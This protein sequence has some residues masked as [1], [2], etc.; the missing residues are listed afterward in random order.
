MLWASCARQSTFLL[1]AVVAAAQTVSSSLE[2]TVADSSR[3]VVPAAAVVLTNLDT[4]TALKTATDNAGSYAFPSI[5]AGTYRL[6]VTRDGFSTYEL[7]QF[8]VAAAQHT[9]Q[10]IVLSVG[11]VTQGVTVNGG[12]LVNV[13]EKSSNDLGTLIEHQSVSELPL[14]GR[15]FLQLGLISGATQTSGPTQNTSMALQYQGAGRSLLTINVGG[16]ENDFTT[17]LIDGLQ[18]V[19]SRAGNMSLGLS[20]GAIDQFQVHYGFFLPDLGP[21]P[22]VVDL[23]TKSGTNHIHGEAYEYLRN[24]DM[25]ARNYFSAT[26]PGPY[27]RNQFG[28][29]MGGPIRKDKIFLFGSYEGLRQV[30]S[31]FAGAFTPTAAMFNGDFSAL[32]AAIYNP[33]SFDPATGKRLPFAGNTIPAN[34][35]NPVSKKLLSYYIPGSSYFQTPF[36]VTGNPRSTLSSDQFLVRGD[37]NL[38]PR[39]R[40]FTEFSYYNS[41]A[42]AQGLFPFAG[43]SFPLDAEM[44]AL[45]WTSTLSATQVNELRLGFVRNSVYSLGAR[46]AGVQNQLG[47]T[48]TADPDGVPSITLSGIGGFGQQAGRLGNIDDS[49]QV[50]DSF[51]WLRG[52]HLIKIGADV[53]YIRSVQDSANAFARG[54]II[55]T[56]AFTPQLAANA[57]GSLAPVAGSGNTVA[58]FLLGMPTSGS[59]ASMPHTHYR[60][61]VFEPYIQD[62]WKIRPGLTLNAGLA[63]FLTTPPNPVGGDANY[64]HGFDFTTGHVLYA[65]LGQIS[66]QVYAMTTSNFA[67]RVGLAWEPSFVKNTVVRAG[68][69][70]YYGQADFFDSQYSIVAPGITIAQTITNRQPSPTYVLGANVLPPISTQTITPAFALTAAGSLNY[71]PP[72]NRTPYVEQWNFDIQHSFGPM[73]LLDVAYMGSEGHHLRASWD[74]NDCFEPQTRQC[75]KPNPYPAFP[76][77]SEVSNVANSNTN[78]LLVKFRR[79]FSNGLS[80]LANYTF[81]KT[82]TASSMGG[83]GLTATDGNCRNCD[84]GPALF[85]VPHA[86]VVSTVWDLPFAR[87]NRW[88]GGWGIDFLAS[89]KKGTPFTVF[90]PNTTVWTQRAVHANRS[91]NGRDELSNKDVRSNGLYWIQTSCFAPPPSGFLGNSGQAIL[92]GPGINT[93]DIGVHKDFAIREGTKLQVRGEFFNAFNHAQFANPDSGSTDVNFGKVIATQ[94]D[95]RQLQVSMRLVF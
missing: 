58:D 13:L 67:P 44:A 15:N 36:N 29:D 9:S 68:W 27:H 8:K 34:L 40:L 54:Q 11:Q 72:I 37:I 48:G 26:P 61:T 3:A 5:P 89:F 80:V 35:L 84:Y 60:W 20:L 45:G 81:S 93:W 64:P 7:S 66:P 38:S 17:Y 33:L 70:I 76:F 14:N 2:G 78:T 65:A 51:S 46:N 71:V 92:T 10:D 16:N 21:N 22:G 24:N 18:T 47:I 19:G 75:T 32:S 57:Q 63:Y 49:Y 30:L 39:N 82:L 83:N 62:T 31:N 50:H 43:T 85:N 95:P 79:Q 52:R 25:D 6:T 91:C 23:L 56:N 59:T 1:F 4:G 42:T 88:I 77:I 94:V 73:Y 90:A 74:A 55:F 28:G 41:P 53:N 12:G 87:R 86:L 69:G